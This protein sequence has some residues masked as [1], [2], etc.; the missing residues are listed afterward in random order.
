VIST[1]VQKSSYLKSGVGKGGG[2]SAII[3]SVKKKNEMN[4]LD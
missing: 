3:T 2:K 4:N 1:K